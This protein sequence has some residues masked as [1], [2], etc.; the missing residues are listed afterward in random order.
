MIIICCWCQCW[1]WPSKASEENNSMD[2]TSASA[3]SIECYIRI[4]YKYKIIIILLCQHFYS[5]ISER[6]MGVL[7]CAAMYMYSYPRR[8]LNAH[9]SVF[10]NALYFGRCY[11]ISYTPIS[12]G[13]LQHYL[14]ANITQFGHMDF[15]YFANTQNVPYV[16]IR[17]QNGQQRICSEEK[18]LYT[19]S[20]PSTTTSV[21]Y[22][23][24]NN[25]SG[26]AKH[27]LLYINALP[28][29]PKI[30]CVAL[31]VPHIGVRSV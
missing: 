17:L 18:N 5:L 11:R 6:Y 16:D 2:S 12:K 27:I 25:T 28:T 3:F 9:S 19:A 8:R 24:K 7:E 20:C 10:I 21:R 31:E 15:K 29:Y 1:H 13:I 30:E 4:T 14:H 22:L 23:F 26:N